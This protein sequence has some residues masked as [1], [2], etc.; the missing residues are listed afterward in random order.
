MLMDAIGAL[1]LFLFVVII[2]V[3][4]IVLYVTYRELED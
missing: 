1:F 2:G 3:G 4:A